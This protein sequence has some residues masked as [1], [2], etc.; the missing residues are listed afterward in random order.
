[1]LHIIIV[2]HI[3]QCFMCRLQ[4]CIREFTTGTIDDAGDDSFLCHIV[5][6]AFV[7][8]FCFCCCFMSRSFLYQN[9]SSYLGTLCSFLA[10]SLHW[11]V[12]LSK[13][14]H[15]FLLGHVIAS[16][17]LDRGLISGFWLMLLYPVVVKVVHFL[18]IFSSS[19]C[20]R[21]RLCLCLG[22]FVL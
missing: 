9:L 1:M 18:I 4:N 11:N 3:N 16:S 21:S 12:H 13:N 14:K 2:R 5:S 19:I 8:V 17:V 10:N 20:N 6:S 7:G 22:L 15:M